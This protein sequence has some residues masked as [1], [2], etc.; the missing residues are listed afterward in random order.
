MQLVRS[1]TTRARSRSSTNATAAAAFSLAYRMVR[2]ARSWPRTSCRRPSCR[3][4]APARATSAPAAR[5]APG[6]SGSSTTA[7]STRCAARRAR[8]APRAAT[9]GIE[10]RFESG[11]RTDVEAARR[12]EAATDP[13]GAW[14]RCRPTSRSVIELAYFGGFTHTEIAEMLERARRHR[15][16]PDAARPGEAAQRSSRRLE[17]RRRHERAR[18]R[19]RP[20]GRLAR[21]L[22]AG[23]AAR[24]RAPPASSATSTSCADVPR[25]RRGAARRRRRAAAPRAAPHTPPP[26]AQGPH[27]GRRREPRPRC[28]TPPA[29]SPTARAAARAPPRPERPASPAPRSRWRPRR[30]AARSSASASACS[31]ARADRR[32]QQTVTAQVA[33]RRP[34]ATLEIAGRP[35]AASSPA[36]S[37]QPPSGRVYQVWLD[38]GGK[39]PAADRRAVH[40]TSSDGSATVAVPPRSTAC[41]GDGHRRARRGGSPTPTGKPV[42]SGR[43]DAKRPLLASRAPHGHLLPPP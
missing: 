7:R 43:A 37:P 12:E 30:A 9:R 26:D 33:A 3:S 28:C 15:E 27:H 38:K 22:A 29:P 34:A 31:A 8:Q 42:L 14:T 4:G 36:S 16:G 40:A 20:V 32:H 1:A 24:R 19:S 17:M 35:C 10:E 39:T 6:C 5:C 21:R 11:E 13:R 23:R 25:G 41:G 2:H 18:P